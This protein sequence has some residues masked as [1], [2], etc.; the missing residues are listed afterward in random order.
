MDKMEPRLDNIAHFRG[1][2]T[3]VQI[4]DEPAGRAPAA[5]L[6]LRRYLAIMAIAIGLGLTTVWVVFLGHVLITLIVLA[7]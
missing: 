2:F 6:Q 1:Q 3:Q 7:T 4:S 5:Y